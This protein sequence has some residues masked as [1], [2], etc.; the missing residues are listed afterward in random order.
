MNVHGGKT[1]LSLSLDLDYFS[2]CKMGLKVRPQQYYGSVFYRSVIQR[3]QPAIGP[4]G[5]SISWH[6]V[7]QRFSPLC[8]SVNMV[9]CVC[10]D[11]SIYYM[12]KEERPADWKCQGLEKYF[13]VDHPQLNIFLFYFYHQEL[14][15]SPWNRTQTANQ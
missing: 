8:C 3:A 12:R 13:K 15:C 6:V 10:P 7:L 11:G 2:S 14:G 4:F 5:T 1:P 9:P